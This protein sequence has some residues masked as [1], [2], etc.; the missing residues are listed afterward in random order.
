[1]VVC[2]LWCTRGG[3]NARWKDLAN[4]SDAMA[5]QWKT[6]KPTKPGRLDCLGRVWGC[7]LLQ[8]VKGTD[9]LIRQRVCSRAEAA[10][11]SCIYR[12]ASGWQQSVI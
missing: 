3:L 1:M 11:R 12:P 5:G 6:W 7:V 10:K 4:P 8:T 2:R 9:G